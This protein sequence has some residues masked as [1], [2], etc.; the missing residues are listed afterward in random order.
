VLK[1]ETSKEMNRLFRLVVERGTA[2]KA[3]VP[4]YPVGGKTGT[5]EKATRHGYA[6]KALL[7]SFIGVFPANSPRYA[8][9][10]IVDEPKGTKETS[11]F[12]TGGWTAAPATSRIVARIAPM[13]GV[14]PQRDPNADPDAIAGGK[15]KKDKKEDE[16]VLMAQDH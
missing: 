15:D 7:S 8:V 2:R 6:R 10:V 11:G 4:G 5:A 12:A 14:E 1:P 3:D 16:A 9:L 13:L